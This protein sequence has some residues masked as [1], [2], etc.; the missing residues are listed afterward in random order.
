MDDHFSH[1][2]WSMS[3]RHDGLEAA[4][5]ARG[6]EREAAGLLHADVSIGSDEEWPVW[7]VLSE[8]GALLITP[9]ILDRE[10]ILVDWYRQKLNSAKSADSEVQVEVRNGVV[11]LMRRVE[12]RQDAVDLI[13]TAYA[14][15]LPGVV[16]GEHV[17]NR[18]FLTGWSPVGPGA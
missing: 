9:V 2:D 18:N 4:L 15:G 5:I 11:C 6:W 14:E 16:I 12:S 13:I 17:E 1:V 10:G 8:D 7:V 3:D